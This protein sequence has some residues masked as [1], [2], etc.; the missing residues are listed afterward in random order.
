MAEKKTTKKKVIDKSILEPAERPVQP[1]YLFSF[2]SL[3][4]PKKRIIISGGAYLDAIALLREFNAYFQLEYNVNE[5]QQ[6]TIESWIFSTIVD[7]NPEF[8][9]IPRFVSEKEYKQ[10]AKYIINKE[11]NKIHHTKLLTQ[12]EAEKEFG[13]KSNWI[14]FNINF[15]HNLR[16]L[17]KENE[18]IKKEIQQFCR[19]YYD[20]VIL[21]T[22]FDNRFVAIVGPDRKSIMDK[23]HEVAENGYIV[24]KNMNKFEFLFKTFKLD[25]NDIKIWNNINKSLP[26]GLNINNWALIFEKTNSHSY[27]FDSPLK[28]GNNKLSPEEMEKYKNDQINIMKEVDPIFKAKIDMYKKFN[29]QNKKGEE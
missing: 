6:D 23:L 8:K 1:I 15:M 3:K 16:E 29:D 13:V 9:F 14:D 26:R 18:K 7:M 5:Y 20:P 10:L 21:Q 28:I 25:Q 4:K 17:N 12:N 2:Y 27:R 22:K 11:W 19:N 24:D